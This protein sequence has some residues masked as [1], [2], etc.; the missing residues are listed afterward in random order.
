MLT[1]LVAVRPLE[2]VIV[3]VYVFVPA[4]PNTP[5]VADELVLDRLGPDIEYDLIVDP[6]DPDAD[7]IAIVTL[8][9]PFTYTP[10]PDGTPL[11]T[12]VAVGLP[13]DGTTLE[14]TYAVK[15]VYLSPK[16]V[17]PLYVRQITVTEIL[18]PFGTLLARP[19]GTV[20][21]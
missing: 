4:L 19:I 13:I 18:V 8:E 21:E 2:S 20:H 5:D 14:G 10:Q 11:S 17:E 15:L 6:Y 12:L 3:Q 9:Y 7:V 1:V 16:L